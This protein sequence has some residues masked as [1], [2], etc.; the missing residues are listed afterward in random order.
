VSPAQGQ[1]LHAS[2]C[3]DTSVVAVMA[4]TALALSAALLGG[5]STMP[6]DP[7]SLDGRLA[8]QVEAHGAEA[9]RSFAAPFS[10]SGN[11]RVGT[12]EFSSPIGTLLARAQWSP[13]GATM[14]GA[15]ETRQYASLDD[16]AQDLL[17]ESIPMAALMAWLRGRPWDGAASQPTLAPTGFNQLGWQ[18]DLSRRAEGQVAATREGPP[19]VTL[20]ARLET[21]GS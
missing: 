21:P 14:I 18:V 10:L 17:G 8:V 15:R 12:L 5:C 9:A 19:R 20:R 2:K 6:R 1:R 4:V 7:G 3:R 13:S 11:E 16:M